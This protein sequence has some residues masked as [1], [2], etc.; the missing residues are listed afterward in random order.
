MQR[1]RLS[2][3]QS[4]EQTRERLV[5][6]SHAVF[7]Q[8]GFAL[9]SVEEITNAAGYSRGAFYSN[10]DDKTELFFELLRRE[11]VEIEAQFHRLLAAPLVDVNH[12]RDQITDYY[13]KLYEQD[14]CSLLWMEAKI[15]AARDEK[16]RAKL[17]IFQEERHKQIAG[18]VE[19]F[20]RLSGVP[21]A[22]PPHE[23]AIGLSALCE[24]VSFA[25][26]CDPQR[27]DAKTASAVLSFFLKSVIAMPPVHAL[28]IV[29]KKAAKR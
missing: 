5:A 13:G 16:F 23:I 17:N 3:E 4:R 9:A 28:P 26:R 7:T 15:V 18:F 6:A 21:P 2:R 20:S 1:Q 25:H 14:T 29:K 11:S 27:I 19:I 22:A 8:K 24:G 10:F 12:L